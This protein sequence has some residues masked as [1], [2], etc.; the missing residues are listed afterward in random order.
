MALKWFQQ[1]SQKACVVGL[2]G[3]PASMVSRF[4][5]QG[6]MPRLRD[7][8]S[9]G[10]MT[11]MTVSLPEISSVSWTTFMTG[12]N[13]GEHGIFGFTDLHEGTYKT[14][15]PS[16][17]EVRTDTIWDRIGAAKMRSVIINQPATYPARPVHGALV[18]GFV[19]VHLERSVFPAKYLSTLQEMDYRVDLD[20]HE[21][22]DQP[23]LLFRELHTLLGLRRRLVDTLW[24]SEQ[25]NLMEVVVTGTD[26]LHHFLWDA[27]EDENHPH[28]A[29]FL[30]YY[31]AVDSFV[32]EIHDRFAATDS[33]NNFFVLSDHGFCGT[34]TEV[35][36]NT[37][38]ADNGQLV[39]TGTDADSLESISERASAFALDPARIYVH[40]RGRYPRG[41]V[42]DTGTAQLKRELSETFLALTDP[43]GRP[44]IRHVF[45]GDDVYSGPQASKGP[46]LLLVP[47]NGFDLKGRLGATDIFAERRLQG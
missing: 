27:Y 11:A 9:R 42:S 4:M 41:S 32:G 16:F 8:V 18:S 36:V 6:V 7:I 24:E 23:E 5:E 12:R 25:W 26:R 14:S 37:V 10:H 21:V 40:R 2:D 22:R 1:P 38:L 28:H 13:P 31:R 30:D 15:F 39:F 20:A 44:V 17:R 19:S 47:H 35:N 33:A 46:D 45:D 3:V 34:H 29:D 43:D